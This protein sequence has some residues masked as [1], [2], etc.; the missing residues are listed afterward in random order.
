MPARR[1]AAAL[2]LAIAILAAPPAQARWTD[3]VAVT[4]AFTAFVAALAAR[5]AEAGLALLSRA[6]PAEWE[7]LQALALRGGRDSVAALAPGRRLV[8]FAMRHH[9][10]EF[11]RGEA[12]AREQIAAA[13]RAG[14]ADRRTIERLEAGDVVVDGAAASARV[15]VSGLPSP[16]RAGF[17][18]EGDGWKLDL[19]ATLDH[20]GRFVARSAAQARASEDAI[21]AGLLLATSNQRPTT[22]IWEPLAAD[23]R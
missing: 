7:A 3:R 6:T 9:E 19:A 5:D 20:A 16:V 13:F 17:V 1:L 23:P 10:P 2:V 12:P 14:L 21:L 22:R 18:R 8:V 4:K 15:Y 11:V